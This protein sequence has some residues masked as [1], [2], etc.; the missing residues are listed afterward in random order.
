MLDLILACLFWKPIDFPKENK[1]A[2]IIRE[3]YTEED[4]LWAKLSQEYF[5]AAKYQSKNKNLE[6]ALETAKLGLKY[7]PRNKRAYSNALSNVGVHHF[8]IAKLYKRLK[9]IATEI[10]KDSQEI[11]KD[12][13][14]K[15]YGEQLTLSELYTFHI[16]KAR[17]MYIKAIEINDKSP[18]FHSNLGNL[19]LQDEKIKEGVELLKSAMELSP[20]SVKYVFE[21]GKACLVAKKYEEAKMYL[22][23]SKT[24]FPALENRV[25]R[26]LETVPTSKK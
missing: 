12:Q 16:T 22:N 8:R 15:L 17:E 6:A 14:E 11:G 13:A 4:D 19:F 10:P 5:E 21:Y 2:P 23:K 9:S 18:V 3:T 20:E 24:L 7:A 26:L 25:K 1:P